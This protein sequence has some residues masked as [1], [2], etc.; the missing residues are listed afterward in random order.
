MSLWVI[1]V[2]LSGL[3]GF[4]C[5]PS[6]SE[7]GSLCSSYYLMVFARALSGCG[8]AALN[9]LSLPF[10]NKILDEESKGFYV[11][12]YYTAIPVGTALGF[13]WAGLIT[14][15][16]G[17]WEWAFLLEGPIMVP[18]V[19]LMMFVPVDIAERYVSKRKERA[20][21][22]SNNTQS[23]ATPIQNV[24]N[25]EYESLNDDLSSD[26]VEGESPPR[27][28]VLTLWN[29]VLTCLTSPAF[30]L[31]ALGYAVYTGV[32]SGMS[33]YGPL[34][35]QGYRPCDAR[36]DFSQDVT[37]IIFG[38]IVA[39]AGFGGT[40]LGGYVV[41]RQMVSS[42][43]ESDTHL[44][45]DTID[46]Q[47]LMKRCKTVTKVLVL[48]LILGEVFAIV[49]LGL[50]DPKAFF[51]AFTLC[52][53]AFFMVT[54]GINLIII[55]SVPVENQPMAMALSVI[56]IHAFGDVPSPILIG[57]ISDTQT[58]LFTIA[59]ATLSMLGAILF[60]GGL[61][62]LPSKRMYSLVSPTPPYERLLAENDN[63][64]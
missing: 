10:L 51:F 28:K 43:D 32:V 2:T 59:V 35:I 14:D 22:I 42:R 11:G 61:Y 64:E 58:P 47:V 5:K 40:I 39:T 8:E 60:W 56:A 1:A 52:V 16:A 18:F 26:I 63:V 46:P 17:G 62:M 3:S 45:D 31:A 20:Q 44:A 6:N 12:V 41:D 33:F 53:S 29:N 55:W 19:I 23:Q 36:W 13:I 27:V 24:S 37:D 7:D 57:Y 30:I 38:L 15:I 4:W 21:Q 50:K 48:E 25:T 54:A 49:M 34:F 9:T